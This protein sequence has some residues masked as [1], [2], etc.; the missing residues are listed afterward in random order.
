MSHSF[1]T[2]VFASVTVAGS[3]ALLLGGCSSP[4]TSTSGVTTA[5]SAGVAPQTTTA[6]PTTTAT[7]AVTSPTVPTAP[8]PVDS[9]QPT[10]PPA[11]TDYIPP[12]AIMPAPQHGPAACGPNSYLNSYDQCVHR[13]E[14]AAAPP[15]GATAR[16]KDGTY[17][18]SKNRS[19]TCS[20][21]G[22]VATWL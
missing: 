22:G 14:S 6:A 1:R 11:T 21:H 13:P 3:F 8:R 10:T 16:C 19:G 2:L 5:P 18:F 7:A 9:T 17:S 20:G 4:P 12:A 15:P